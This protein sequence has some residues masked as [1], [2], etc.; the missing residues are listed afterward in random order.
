MKTG[1]ELRPRTVMLGEQYAEALLKPGSNPSDAR[2]VIDQALA[3]GISPLQLYVEVIP[4]AL[5]EVGRRWERG[6]I[7][8]AEEHLATAAAQAVLRDLSR[9][10][11]ASARN[12]K[13]A[14]VAAVEGELHELGPRVLA[15]LLESDGWRVLYVG[16]ATPTDALVRLTEERRP[17]V[18]ALSATLASQLRALAD[19]VARIRAASSSPFILVG[20]QA[21]A[22]VPDVATKVGADAT[23][24]RADRA[25]ALVRR[26]GVDRDRTAATEILTQREHEVLAVLADGMTNVEIANRLG[27]SVPTVKTH[28]EHIL[29]KLNLRNRT[30]AAAFV[31]RR[32]SSVAGKPRV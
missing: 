10:L 22:D 14:V 5:Y 13:T 2:H 15:D 30:E 9:R 4:E 27:V 3:A 31:G 21:C 1:L 11:P 24:T 19:A 16:A 29:T 7:S 23:E 32:S 18:V 28:V 25:V 6:E 17:D 20:G 8:V 12:G 26:V